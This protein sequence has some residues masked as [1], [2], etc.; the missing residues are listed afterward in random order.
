MSW[1]RYLDFATATGYPLPNPVRCHLGQWQQQRFGVWAPLDLEAPA[2]HVSLADANAW[3]R[4]A[5]RSLPTEA[6]WECAAVN[7]SD[8]AW[9]EVWEWTASVFEPFPGFVAHPYLDYSAPWFGSR[10][11]LRGACTATA[12]TMVSP[13]YRNFF[14]PERRDIFAG[15]RTVTTT[16]P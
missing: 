2:V 5:G 16:R 1:A 3:C 14:A 12:T 9:G 15:F 8:M 7:R 4:W 6:Q 13:R 10:Q 11:V